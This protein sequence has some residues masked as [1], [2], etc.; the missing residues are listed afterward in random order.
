MRHLLLKFESAKLCA[1]TPYTVLIRT[2]RAYTPARLRAL[3]ALI[4]ALR[5]HTLIY[6][7]LTH[8]RLVLCYVVKV[9]E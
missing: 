6:S 3:R 4:G 2:L 7:S 1:Y 5:A 9:E 8:L